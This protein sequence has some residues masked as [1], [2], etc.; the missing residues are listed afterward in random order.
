MPHTV[1]GTHRLNILNPSEANPK[2]TL[3]DSQAKSINSESK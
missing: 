2:Q 1:R 3:R